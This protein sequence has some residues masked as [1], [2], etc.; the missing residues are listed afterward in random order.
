[1]IK[2]LGFLKSHQARSDNEPLPVFPSFIFWGM[3]LD[4]VFWGS[5]P[6][7][8]LRVVLSHG[9]TLSGLEGSFG[10]LGSKLTSIASN[11]NVLTV[12][13]FLWYQ[14]LYFGE[15]A[16]IIRAGRKIDCRESENSKPLSNTVLVICPETHV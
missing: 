15:E 6:I 5:S 4:F 1:M 10:M 2:M 8:L 9:T 7:L 16:K 13:L 11:T 3:G 14:F 12:A